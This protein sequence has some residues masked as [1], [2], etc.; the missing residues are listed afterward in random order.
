VQIPTAV[1]SLASRLRKP[2]PIVRSLPI[3]LAIVG[4]TG[5]NAMQNRQ[6][7]PPII[8]GAQVEAASANKF[9]LLRAL[10][11]DASIRGELPSDW[12]LVAEAGFNFIDD[13]CR[14]YFDELFFLN[15]RAERL[16]TGLTVADKTTAAILAVTGATTPT[17]NIVAQAFGVGIHAVDL[18]AGT[19]LYQLPPATTQ[20]FVTKLQTAYRRG[21]ARNRSQIDTPTAAYHAIQRYLDLCLPPRIEAEIN[22][23]VNGTTARAVIGDGSTVDIETASP[24]GPAPVDTLVLPSAPRRAIEPGNRQSN[25]RPGIT[26]QT[27]KFPEA[28][29]LLTPYREKLHTQRYVVSVQDS[30]CVPA[31]ER[32][33]VGP[34]TKALVAIFEASYRRATKDGKLSDA[35]V[36]EI[37]GQGTC[38]LGGPRNYFEKRTYP[39]NA[40]GVSAV[41]NLI[42]GL[43]RTAAGK[44]LPEGTTLEGARDVIAQVRA[45]PTIRPKLTLQMP[46][47]M[48][49]QVTRDLLLALPK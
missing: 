29:D 24:P 4:L 9:V 32:G 28:A 31:S 13:Q 40:D 8:D 1:T 22:K 46:A 2:W 49:K 34:M 14:A 45:D 38:V 16:K 25:V 5:C 48:E 12:Y 10:A 17:M 26:D 33:T 7:P 21:A 18:I 11:S 36:A 15:R 41:A 42:A 43:R 20:G 37:K 30:L 35:E 47:G 44:D 3:A 19:Y 23:Q 6:G 39:D 27:P